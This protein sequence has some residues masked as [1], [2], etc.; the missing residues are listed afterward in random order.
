MIRLA[1]KIFDEFPHLG[2]PH[3]EVSSDRIL[4]QTA[5]YLH[6]I[7]RSPKA[8][9]KGEH[10]EKGFET[11][12][13]VIPQYMTGN[14]LVGDELG[15]L[16]Y[17]V[18]FHREHDF[19]ERS[20]VPLSDPQRTKQLAAILRIA[21]ELDHGP[22]FNAPVRDLNLGMEGNIIICQVF[23]RSNSVQG[24]WMDYVKHTEVQNVELVQEVYGR[25]QMKTGQGT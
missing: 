8:I 19:S 14:L 15:I 16:L 10:N 2:L 12:R 5:G 13:R 25:S 6:D 23:P 22:P 20:G 18:L 21:D 4:I 11:I 24:Q 3:G 7:G 9:G 1:L 17:C